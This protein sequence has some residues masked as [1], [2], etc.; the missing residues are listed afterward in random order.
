MK[1][2][3]KLDLIKQIKNIPKQL[4]WCDIINYESENKQYKISLKI[5]LTKKGK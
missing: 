1:D 2:K 5:V 4:N 3:L